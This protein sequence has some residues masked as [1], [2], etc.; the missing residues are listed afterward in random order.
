MNRIETGSL[1][2]GTPATPMI[3]VVDTEATSTSSASHLLRE[4]RVTSI[5][6][7]NLV[8]DVDCGLCHLIIIIVVVV[9]VVVVVLVAVVV[10]IVV[11]VVVVV[12]LV[13]VVVVVVVVVVVLVSV[14][15][16]VVVLVAVVVVVVVVVVVGLLVVILVVVVVAVAVVVVNISSSSNSTTMKVTNLRYRRWKASFIPLYTDTAIKSLFAVLL[17]TGDYGSNCFKSGEKARFNPKTLLA[18]MK[19][20]YEEVRNLCTMCSAT[21]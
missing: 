5:T 12:V 8:N 19:A 1:S 3:T 10:V 18:F 7:R 21:V 11:V 20:Q 14:V 16:V 6:C 15:V 9:V 13:A 2:N 4:K 17:C